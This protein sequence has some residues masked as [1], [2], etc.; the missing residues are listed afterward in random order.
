MARIFIGA[1][2]FS[3]DDW[4]GPVYPPGLPKKDW[5]GFYAREFETTEVNATYYRIPPPS[6]FQRMIE[7]T[8][9][10]F[11]FAVKAFQGLTHERIAARNATTFTQF[12]EAIRPLEDEGRLG[13]ILAQFPFSFHATTENRD[14]LKTVRE[15]LGDRPT[16]VEFRNDQWLTEETFALLRELSLGFCCVDEPRLQGLIPPIAVT[17]S[18]IAYVRFHGRNAAKWWQHKHAWERY[19]YTY[20]EAELAE[21]VPKIQELARQSEQVYLFANNHWQGQAVGTARQLKMLLGLAET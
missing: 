5:L 17:T 12:C 20:K 21:W 19:D 13:C 6:T 15:R 14:Y 9:A 8:P 2:G 18:P 3:Y 1:S 16:A 7:K 11:R 4:V 10:G